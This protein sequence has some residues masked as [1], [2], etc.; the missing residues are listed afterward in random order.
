MAYNH[1]TITPP[2]IPSSLLKQLLELC[3]KESPF[4]TP[5]GKIYLKIEGVAM[6]NPLGPSFANFYMGYLEEQTFA[7]NNNKL[8]IYTRYVDNIFV[9]YKNSDDLNKLKTIFEENS[10]LKFTV[11]KSTDN[12]LPFL[13]VLLKNFNNISTLNTLKLEWVIFAH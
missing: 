2:K 11:D 12:K 5:E 10:I 13:D 8:P 4:I 3:T 7:N 9:R 1:P 6:D